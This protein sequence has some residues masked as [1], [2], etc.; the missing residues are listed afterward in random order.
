MEEYFV[1]RINCPCDNW[2]CVPCYESFQGCPQC[3]TEQVC[4]RF[5]VRVTS[6]YYFE[7]KFFYDMLH[8]LCLN[9]RR[10]MCDGI[11]LLLLVYLMIVSEEDELYSRQ[12]AYGVILTLSTEVFRQFAFG[13]YYYT[14]EDELVRSRRECVTHGFAIM[15]APA[16][17]LACFAGTIYIKNNYIGWGIEVFGLLRFALN[18]AFF[19]P[20]MF[21][22]HGVLID[23]NMTQLSHLSHPEVLVVE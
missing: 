6:E 9:A 18:L 11:W 14:Y 4:D 7:S 3:H 22:Q 10:R 13:R 19:I 12:G 8:S 15:F 21:C 17:D 16:F 2:M 1:I 23:T 20:S 5:G